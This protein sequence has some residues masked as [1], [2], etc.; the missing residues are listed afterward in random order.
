[1][2]KLIAVA[3]VAVGL[4]FSNGAV[5]H[6]AMAKHGGV[7]SSAGDLAFE[8]VAKDGKA[9]IYIQDHGRELPTRGANGNLTVLQGTKKFETALEASEP[10]T[11]ISKADVK[12]T[13]G[14]KAVASITLA[15]KEP[16]RVRFSAK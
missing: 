8:L 11:L 1:M 6:G 14:T 5:A 13:K 16:I 12:L 15:G 10:N 7:V 4:T 3:T 2:K 9:V